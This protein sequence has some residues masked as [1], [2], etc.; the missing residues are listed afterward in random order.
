MEKEDD[1]F[2]HWFCPEKHPAKLVQIGT[3]ASSEVLAKW[4]CIECGLECVARTTVANLLK[5]PLVQEE[6]SA[7]QM[8]DIR[9]SNQITDEDLPFLR[10]LKI[11]L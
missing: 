5:L 10:A 11:T 9:A 7:V 4:K 6:V 3:S 8:A 2:Y 1:R